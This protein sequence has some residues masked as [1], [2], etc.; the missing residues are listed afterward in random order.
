MAIERIVLATDSSSASEKAVAFVGNMA[1]QNAQV[2]IVSVVENFS[3]ISPMGPRISAVLNAARAEMLRDAEDSLKHAKDIFEKAGTSVDTQVIDLSKKGGDIAHALID[4]A[5]AQD[6]DLLVVGA[7]QHHGLLRW[8]EGTVSGHLTKHGHCAILIVPAEYNQQTHGAPRRILFAL[9]GSSV[10]IDALRIGVQMAAPETQLRAIYVV[11]HGVRLSDFV[12]I[13]LMENAFSKEGEAALAN[14]AAVFA[15]LPN[16]IE[17][18]LIDTAIAND[19]VPHTIVREA[20]RWDADLVVM[21]T[22]GRRGAASW[23]IGSVANRVARITNI[24]L[25]LGR[26]KMAKPAGQ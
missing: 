9:D 19:D 24:P 14:A 12:P 26:D 13:H 20:A 4:V 22:H 10:S 3:T 16:P 17:T 8:M 1:A 23:F 21:G 15:T 7:R 25:L 11:D 2:H 18:G 6:A 5:D